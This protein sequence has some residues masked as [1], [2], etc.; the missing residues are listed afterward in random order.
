MSYPDG[1]W[2]SHIEA[3]AWAVA[4]T[5]GPVVEMGAGWYST[6]LLHGLC[7]ALGR[8]LWTFEQDDRW[9]EQVSRAWKSET[10]HWNEDFPEGF[11]PGLVFVDDAAGNRA[12]NIEWAREHKAQMVAVHDTEPVGAEGYPGMQEALDKFKYQ[13]VWDHFPAHT[14]VVSNK[15]VL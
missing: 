1:C 11:K 14:T 12:G 15:V 9:R 3:L 5:K 2:S 8:D 4:R 13:R 10:H 7:E 6:P